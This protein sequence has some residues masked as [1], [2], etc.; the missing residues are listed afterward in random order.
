MLK[1]SGPRI[2]F[3]FNVTFEC[4]A[5]NNDD[6]K[7]FDEND[8]SLPS[9]NNIMVL[10]YKDVLNLTCKKVIISIILSSFAQFK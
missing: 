8:Q 1:I 3:D 9:K 6:E 10:K 5:E 7:K 4:N 2:L